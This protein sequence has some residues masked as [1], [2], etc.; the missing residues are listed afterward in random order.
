MMLNKL[1]F[2]RPGTQL[3][4]LMPYPFIIAIYHRFLEG[5]S[6]IQSG[7]RTL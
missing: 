6:F 1:F 2:G 7:K 3:L 4:T 5:L